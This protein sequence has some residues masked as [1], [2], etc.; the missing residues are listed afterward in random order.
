MNAEHIA[1]SLGGTAYGDSY[2]VCCPGHADRTPSLS[3]KQ[4]ADKVLLKCFGGCEQRRVI[5]SLRQMG[6]WDSKSANG[7]P[8]TTSVREPDPKD[9]ERKKQWLHNLLAGASTPT[10]GDPVDLHF[11]M[12]RKI[13]LLQYP[14]SILFHPRMAYFVFDKAA[15]R[16]IV[17]SYHPGMVQ[18]ITADDGTLLG[19]QRVY[20]QSN[21]QKADLD[22]VKM[23]MPS[24]R[25]QVHGAIRLCEP[26]DVLA[27]AEGCES[28]M[29]FHALTR[30]P[31]W[32]AVHAHGMEV[33][34][35]PEQ[36][37]TVFICVDHDEAGKRSA[38][39]LTHRLLLEGRKVFQSLPPF[40]QG[41]A[42]KGADWS[43]YLQEIRK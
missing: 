10:H 38:D 39:K 5:E 29:A 27:V 33:L 23:L 22:P 34:T 13:P 11:R 40:P 1:E 7:Q 15:G 12:I 43:T 3:I 31:A 26:T 36:V 16:K 6:L 25:P 14:E 30:L 42:C 41:I 17:Q 20:L 4:S 35:I 24:F 37:R 18:V 8:V 2:L 21:G 9:V 32:S 28:A 19:A